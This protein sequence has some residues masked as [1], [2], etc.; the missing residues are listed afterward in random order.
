MYV[1]I[2]TYLDF[3]KGMYM[4]QTG[5]SIFKNVK[6]F[7]TVAKA[8]KFILS[9]ARV[10]NLPINEYYEILEIKIVEPAP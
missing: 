2:N 1:D 3:E 6:F 9:S 5:A 10:A 7:S 4:S 8:K